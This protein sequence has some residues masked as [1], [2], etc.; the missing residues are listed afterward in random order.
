LVLF[1]D[2]H[3]W[4]A[5]LRDTVLNYVLPR[6][7]TNNLLI[8]EHGPLYLYSFMD[9]VSVDLILVSYSSEERQVVTTLVTDQ[10]FYRVFY[11]ITLS[12]QILRTKGLRERYED[13]K[14]LHFGRRLNTIPFEV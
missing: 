14:D 3:C 11:G 4:V 12:K 5:I 10:T 9:H 2:N 1:I 8:I 13:F 6:P 7:I